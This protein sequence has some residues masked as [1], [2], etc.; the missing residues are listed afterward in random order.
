MTD[1]DLLEILECRARG[2]NT[3]QTSARLGITKNA[4]IGA[5]H[6]IDR[7]CAEHPCMAR[8][9]KNKDGSQKPRWWDNAKQRARNVTPHR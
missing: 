9:P 3:V 1:L 5:L 7:D 4:V 8:K 6:R 2:L